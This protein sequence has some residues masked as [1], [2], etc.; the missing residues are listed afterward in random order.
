M[1]PAARLSAALLS[2]VW[3]SEV[4]RIFHPM[5]WLTSLGALCLA[6]YMTM[7]LGR[8][9]AH[10]RAVFVL[11][12][13]A[14]A[15]MAFH[16][17]SPGALLAGFDK[18]QIFGAFLPAALLLRATVESSPRLETIRVSLRELPAAAVLSGTQLSSHT[19]G[20]VLNAGAAAILAPVVAPGADS[21]RR[22]ELARSCARGIGGAVMWSPFFPALAFTGQLV[23]QEP[24]WQAM[25]IGA[26]LAVLGFGLSYAIFTPSLRP[27]ALFASVRA[28]QPLFGPVSLLIAAVVGSTIAFGWN[29][30]QSVAFLV[31]LI[32][33]GYLAHA[34]WAQIR[35]AAASATSAFA[36]LS[37]ELLIVVGAT[38]LGSSIAALPE[39]REL[40]AALDPNVVAGPLL[41]AAVILALLLLGQAGLHPMIG[42]SVVVPLVAAG[43][44]GVCGPV[45][46]AAAVFAW[47]LFGSTAIWAL[48]VVASARFFDVHPREMLSRKTGWYLLS[49]VGLAYPALLAVNLWLGSAGCR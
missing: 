40:G 28:L 35:R 25:V 22:A 29:G 44:F 36:L 10:I 31:P 24:L 30:L 21:A 6:T 47:A 1:S 46:V 33:A 7:A 42:A 5:Q 45:L 14:S 17:G 34:G 48:P 3:A 13:A 23:P 18:G 37:N 39:V 49:Y 16:L 4:I 26:G 12:L 8:A 15:G 11:A 19:M 41:L 27:G 38:I 43:D 9:S 2:I 20:S 32:C